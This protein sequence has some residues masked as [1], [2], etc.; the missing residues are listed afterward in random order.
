MAEVDF[1]FSW[2]GRELFK[3]GI[4]IHILFTI[5][6]GQQIRTKLAITIFDSCIQ[7]MV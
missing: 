5:M 3:G 2:G 6:L 1:F 7:L 4:V